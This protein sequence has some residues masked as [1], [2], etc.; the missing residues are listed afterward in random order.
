MILLVLLIVGLAIWRYVN[1]RESNNEN[2]SIENIVESNMD[3][4]EKL[5]K[6][7]EEIDKKRNK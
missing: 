6:L 5:Q 2:N 4:N 1:S 3:Y 7:Q